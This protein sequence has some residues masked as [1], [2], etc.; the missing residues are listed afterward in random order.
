M[1]K[2]V[3]IFAAC[4][5][6]T[7]YA[8]AQTKVPLSAA[9]KNIGKTV[10]ICDKISETKF[11]ESAKTQPTLLNMG[12]VAPNNKLTVVINAENR[13]SFSYKPEETLAG[14][15]VCV[16]GK[17]LDFK[18]KPEI[19]VTKPDQIQTLNE[20]GGGEIPEIRTRDFLWF[21]Q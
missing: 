20:G 11:L 1:R 18:G 16:T 13:K 9:E 6:Y 2:L 19:I 7:I 5:L 14:R 17:L 12:G 3:A 4:L 8:T 10:T 21:E 15:N